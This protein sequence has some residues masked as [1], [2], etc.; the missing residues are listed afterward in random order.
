MAVEKGYLDVAMLIYACNPI[1][2]EERWLWVDAAS[3]YTK[4]QD[5]IDWLQQITRAPAS[6]RLF[7][8]RK[9]RLVLGYDIEQKSAATRI[10][11]NAEELP[12]SV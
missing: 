5:M 8:R 12:S 1:V 9:L 11:R 3:R 2:Y 6:L 7:C 4:D 10:S